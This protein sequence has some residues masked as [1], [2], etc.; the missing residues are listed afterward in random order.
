MSGLSGFNGVAKLY[1][2][3]GITLPMGGEACMQSFRIMGRTPRIPREAYQGFGRDDVASR[4]S[5]LKT[6]LKWSAR[7]RP[8]HVL[9][10]RQA[11][12][13]TSPREDTVTRK[14][15]DLPQRPP[16]RPPRDTEE[17]IHV[18]S[19]PIVSGAG[20]GLFFFWYAHNRLLSCM[21]RVL[22]LSTCI[23]ML[24]VTCSTQTVREGEAKDVWSLISH[25]L[26]NPAEAPYMLL[27]GRGS[28]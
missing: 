5:L 27:S 8:R 3:P 4:L 22:S 10:R 6:E 14:D 17:S 21:T 15:Y 24:I 18:D 2:R 9:H 7:Q 26:L 13:Q 19:T 28:S 23:V 16:A 1:E 11:L 20:G 25:M 12:P